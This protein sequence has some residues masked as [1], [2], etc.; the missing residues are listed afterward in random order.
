MGQRDLRGRAGLPQTRVEAETSR[1]T[2]EPAPITALSP[3][4]TP[5]S[6]MAPPP[7]QTLLPMVTGRAY[8]TPV[9]RLSASSGWHAV[10]M[11]T[12]GPMKALSP[13]RTSASSRMVRLKLAKKFSPTWMLQ[14]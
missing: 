14:P 5:G 3:T 7:I 6:R 8:S 1:V 2:T 9:L 13:M 11:L 10:K 4:V 12:L